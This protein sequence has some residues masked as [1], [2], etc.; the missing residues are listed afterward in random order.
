M[1]H[2]YSLRRGEYS[3]A[4]QDARIIATSYQQNDTVVTPVRTRQIVVLNLRPPHHEGCWPLAA[5]H[6]ANIEGLF[7][8]C[9]ALE[10]SI[11]FAMLHVCE[12]LHERSY[13][14]VEPRLWRH[15]SNPDRAS[16]A[17]DTPCLDAAEA[18]RIV[19]RVGGAA[20]L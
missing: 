10:W 8:R 6:S 3:N 18:T 15:P 14:G 11:Q 1:L 17:A 2:T 5:E 9:L 13:D 7:S 20:A 4:Q 19:Y 12:T 16:V